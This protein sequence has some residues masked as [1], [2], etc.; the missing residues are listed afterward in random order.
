[1]FQ[2][3]IRSILLVSCLFILQRTWSLIP[4]KSPIHVHQLWHRHND[5]RKMDIFMAKNKVIRDVEDSPLES[6]GGVG[7]FF[8]KVMRGDSNKEI[9][10]QSE[11][12]R[13]K[14]KK[15]GVSRFF[16]KI[17]D[18][19]SE[20][21]EGNRSG[22]EKQRDKDKEPSFFRSVVNRLPGRNDDDE[23][24]PKQRASRNDMKETQREK[25][26]IFN[27]N[28]RFF[29]TTKLVGDAVGSLEN[30]VLSIRKKIED[31]RSSEILEDPEGNF[32]SQEEEKKRI[33]GVRAQLEAK[34]KKDKENLIVRQLDAELQTKIKEERQREAQVRAATTRLEIKAKEQVRKE[35]LEL[36][37]KILEA[38]SKARS[39]FT[40][41][42][43]SVVPANSLRNQTTSDPRGEK[44]KQ[45]N[46]QSV[47]QQ[48]FSR[49]ES[50]TSNNTSVKSNT[51]SFSFPNPFGAVQRLAYTVWDSTFGGEKGGVEEWVVVFPKTRLDPGE[52]VPVSV[53][54]IDLL[55]VASVDGKKIY[56]IANSCPHLG[57]PLET[58][59]LV[60]RPVEG[61]TRSDSP[62][63]C[64]DCIVCP[65]HQTAFALESGE[66]RGEWCPYPPLLGAVMGAV[67]KK[68]PVAVFDIRTR[69]KNVEVKIN[70]SLE[71]LEK[72]GKKENN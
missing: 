23:A 12:S 42:R 59:P 54:G 34:R 31:V 44:R 37:R 67:K 36:N 17:F 51:S 10:D 65:L 15:S 46:P 27:D 56:S 60:R 48:F 49:S 2:R 39:E 64:E 38:S 14:Q 62:D 30:T 9:G 72:K 40:F 45:K 28:P 35:Q 71:D 4:T 5:P 61:A 66:V 57:T 20:N 52:V 11:G 32:L 55:V 22:S 24:L 43:A 7:V 33:K 58:G 50:E 1:M 18:G 70:S 53:G 29:D 41:G 47:P 21:K 6:R 3:L 25:R 19:D 16:S 69:G 68:S 13:E 8:N 26:T 63:G